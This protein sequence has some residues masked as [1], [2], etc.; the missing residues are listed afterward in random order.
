MGE[1]DSRGKKKGCTI[2]FAHD[3]KGQSCKE[4]FCKP[5]CYYLLLLGRKK[6]VWVFAKVALVTQ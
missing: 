3:S 5:I 2:F 6:Y 1:G 4:K